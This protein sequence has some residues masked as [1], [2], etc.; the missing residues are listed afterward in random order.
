MAV[1]FAVIESMTLSKCTR[2]GGPEPFRLLPF[3]KKL[4]GN[5]LGWKRA[6][7]S[8]LYRRAFFSTARKNSKS[9]CAAA[10]ALLLLLDPG[11]GSP[12]VYVASKS[13]DQSA[14]PFPSRG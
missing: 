2:S 3:Q 6:D 13:R 5:L 9:Q 10:L 8:R 1:D 11:E 7:G 14:Y 4:I 12:E